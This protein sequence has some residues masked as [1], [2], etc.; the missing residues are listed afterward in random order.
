MRKI[1]VA[2]LLSWSLCYSVAYAD[3]IRGRLA[4]MPEPQL[5]S[6]KALEDIEWCLGVEF[7][8][9]FMPSTLHGDKQA[10]IYTA[11]DGDVTDVI[12]MSALIRDEGDHRT[13]SYHAPKA[14]SDRTTRVVKSCI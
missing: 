3:T 8:E 13:V 7:G 10:F 12:I 9:F 5:T 4:K 14:W 2:G 11:V 6:Q 1:V